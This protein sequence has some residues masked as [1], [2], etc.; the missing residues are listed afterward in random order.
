MWK[1]NGTAV[2]L[3]IRVGIVNAFSDRSHILPSIKPRLISLLFL[4]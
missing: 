4:P 2:Q 3:N 1:I